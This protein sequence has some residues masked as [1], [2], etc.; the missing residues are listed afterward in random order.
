MGLL[1][2]CAEAELQLPVGAKVSP[3]PA[4]SIARLRRPMVSSAERLR[5][6]LALLGSPYLVLLRCYQFSG[7]P[8]GGPCAM[9]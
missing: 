2:I 6:Q 1:A 4:G 5:P 3:V 9:L 8:L 7:Q